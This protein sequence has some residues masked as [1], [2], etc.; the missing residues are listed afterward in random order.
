MVCDQGKVSYTPKFDQY[1]PSHFNDHIVLREYHR[2]GHRNLNAALENN[3][4][5]IQ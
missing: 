4:S 3:D 1:V 2:I 5:Y